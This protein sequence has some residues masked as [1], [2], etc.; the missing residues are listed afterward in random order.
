MKTQNL[1]SDFCFASF[2]NHL[3]FLS[4]FAGRKKG[5]VQELVKISIN[6]RR[7]CYKKER[8]VLVFV[9]IDDFD[10]L[11]CPTKLDSRRIPSPIAHANFEFFVHTYS[12]S[13]Y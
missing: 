11:L 10:N 13:M 9:L 2:Y 6:R 12:K 3:L 1:H 7:C 4:H 8:V 5:C